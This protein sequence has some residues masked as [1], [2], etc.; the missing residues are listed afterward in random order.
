MNKPFLSQEAR[1]E[2]RLLSDDILI[3]TSVEIRRK[4]LENPDDGS[5]FLG[6]LTVGEELYR[7]NLTLPSYDC[8]VPFNAA[9]KAFL[10]KIIS[11]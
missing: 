5:L 6:M 7:R 1:Q 2:L 10:E 11:D 9:A 3:T 8:E 4:W